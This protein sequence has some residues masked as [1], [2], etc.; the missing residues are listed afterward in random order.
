MFEDFVEVDLSFFL[1]LSKGKSYKKVMIF[2]ND[3]KEI[4]IYTG[5]IGIIS[6]V[7]GIKDWSI[8]E[9]CTSL[10]SYS[11]LGLALIDHSGK[12]FPFKD[13]KAS[14]FLRDDLSS[15]FELSGYYCCFIQVPKNIICN[16]FNE[17]GLSKETQLN[18]SLKEQIKTGGICKR[19]KSYD[20]YAEIKSDGTCLCYKCFY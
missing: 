12:L 20:E 5:V 4:R 6:G 9:N 11:H 15:Y 3:I 2:N 14:A 1:P 19:C 7:I 8:P 16:L 17:L 10:D 18:N 13:L